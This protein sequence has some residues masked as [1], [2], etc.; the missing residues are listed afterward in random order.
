MEQ[1]TPESRAIYDLLRIETAE[2]HDARFLDYKK[3]TL[4]AVHKFVTDTGKQIK[5]V[6]AAVDSV[7][8]AVT[9]DMEEFRSSIGADLASVKA[10]LSAE[11]SSLAGMIARIPRPDPDALA[12]H[13]SASHNK[14]VKRRRRRH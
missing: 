4:D 10:S 14:E 3:E 6:S 1:L 9:T 7:R 8:S 5:T 2:E 11:I 13:A 12:D